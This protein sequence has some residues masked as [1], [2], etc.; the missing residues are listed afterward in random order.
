MTVFSQTMLQ[1]ETIVALSTAPGIGAIALVRMTG[2]EAVSIA[3]A[4]F[5]KD[6]SSAQSAKAI[7][8]WIMDGEQRIDDVLLTVF[9]GP[10]SF[11]GEDIERER[12]S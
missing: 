1:E 8:G 3:Q 5:S 10:N 9:R 4:V 6:I 12:E 11:T 2:P 7:H